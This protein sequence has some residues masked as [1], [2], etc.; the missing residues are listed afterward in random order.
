MSQMKRSTNR[1][2]VLFRLAIAIT[3]VFSTARAMANLQVF[4]TRVVLSD[5]I[6][7]AQISVRHR[8]AKKMRY[9]IDVVYYKMKPDGSMEQI[10]D[11]NAG[12]K[13]AAGYFRYSPRQVELEPNVEQVV[14]LLLRT[15][16]E[17]AEGDY[18]AHLY[19]EGMDEG[20]EQPVAATDPNGAQMLL[21][22][23]IAVAVPVVVR[24]GKPRLTVEL[25]NLKLNKS[26]QGPSSYS[27][28]VTRTGDA[29]LYGDFFV[30]H[31]PAG[32]KTPVL[33][34]QSNGVSSYIEKRTVSYPLTDQNLGKGELKVELREP[35]SD[36]GKVL[37]T[38]S[39]ELK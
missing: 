3:I 13:T 11:V 7:T 10:K 20:D 35:S 30:Y 38:V 34:S 14:R 26:A 8:G 23:R 15:P 4:P 17:L 33:V 12:E 36:G 31:T 27:V 29:F 6:K 18:R 9:R 22:A 37:A 21:K 28:E 5:Q 39:T 2:L 25:S 16:P 24:K 1:K 32:G 19:F